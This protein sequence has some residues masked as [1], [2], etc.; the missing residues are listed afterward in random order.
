[1]GGDIETVGA[2][3]E[4]RGFLRGCPTVPAVGSMPESSSKASTRATFG[5]LASVTAF[6]VSLEREPSSKR[7]YVLG[8]V[9][10]ISTVLMGMPMAVSGFSE[11][12]TPL[13]LG[14]KRRR[15]ALA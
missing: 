2:P 3:Q 14:S 8:R 9:D 5:L 13:V 10:T 1:M 6:A 12:S 4:A 11:P 7:V 15:Y